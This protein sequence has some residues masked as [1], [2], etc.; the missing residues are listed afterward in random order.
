MAEVWATAIGAAVSVAGLALSATASGGSAPAAPKFTK[1]DPKKVQAQALATDKA[2]YALSDLKYKERFP[3][4]VKARDYM[5]GDI[6]ANM[7]NTFGGGA[8][9]TPVVNQTLADAGLAAGFNGTS[10]YFPQGQNQYDQ[11]KALGKPILSMEQRGRKYFQNEIAMNPERQFGLSGQDIAHIAIANVGGQN[12][13]N[14][15]LFGVRLGQYNQQVAQQSDMTQG[16][17]SG[18]GS[19]VR[20]GVS[21]Y[22]NTNSLDPSY[23]SSNQPWQQNAART[24][25]PT[26]G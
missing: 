10:G 12:N 8:G 9:M 26:P 22:Q 5:R 6:V 15:G 18:L 16:L 11:A 24:Q 23:Y 1:I 3:D 13:F 19:I 17:I 14:Q 25:Y 20:S 21:L 2:S 7:S 4:L